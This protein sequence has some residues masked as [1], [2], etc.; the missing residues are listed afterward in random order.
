MY[1]IWNSSIKQSNYIT[2][3]NYEISGF[4][5]AAHF[6]QYLLVVDTPV[7]FGVGFIAHQ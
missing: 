4:K 6:L 1:G 3:K 2:A 5:P 7:K